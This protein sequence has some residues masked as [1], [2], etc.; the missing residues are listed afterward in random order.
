MSIYWLSLRKNIQVE[1]F[2]SSSA[3]VENPEKKTSKNR[4]NLLL[5]TQILL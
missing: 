3:E 4:N 2:K 1:L 5:S